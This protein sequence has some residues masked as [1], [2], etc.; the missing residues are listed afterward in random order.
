MSLAAGP[1]RPV[2][3]TD[4]E[5]ALCVLLERLR[6]LWSG[7]GRQ[8]WA[9]RKIVERFAAQLRGLGPPTSST[10]TA[11]RCSPMRTAATGMTAPFARRALWRLQGACAAGSELA[12]EGLHRG[13][14][15]RAGGSCSPACR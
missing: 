9:R 5:R 14:R 13:P 12:T 11:T 6:P 4:S 2:G 3:E 10:A 8:A 1:F 7:V 15:R